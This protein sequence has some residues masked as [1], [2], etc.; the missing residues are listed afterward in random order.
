TTRPLIARS[1]LRDRSA[2]RIGGFVSSPPPNVAPTTATVD[3]LATQNAALQ[4]ELVAIKSETAVKVASL[5]DTIANLAHENDLLRRR[6]YGNR[7]ERS[8]TSEMQ[9]A[10][11]DLLAGEAELQKALDG[12][13]GKVQRAVDPDPKLSPGPRATPKGRRDLKL[14]KLPRV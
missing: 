3:E 5:E 13:V 4:A 1:G 11:G 7:T 8:H 9:L 10:L 2:V 6:L 12:A 14:S